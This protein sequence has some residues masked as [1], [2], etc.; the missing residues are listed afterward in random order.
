[1]VTFCYNF[2]DF[3]IVECCSYVDMFIYKKFRY[4]R[5]NASEFSKRP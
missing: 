1:M 2:I 4:R 3:Q 5:K